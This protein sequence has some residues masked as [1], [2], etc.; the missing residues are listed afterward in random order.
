MNLNCPILFLFGEK[1]SEFTPIENRYKQM[2]SQGKQNISLYTISLV[3]H[4]TI[5]PPNQEALFA[6][7]DKWLNDISNQP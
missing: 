7:I 1:D 5:A 6:V 3:G 2:L 4:E